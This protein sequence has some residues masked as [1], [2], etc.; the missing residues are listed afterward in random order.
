MQIF[1]TVKCEKEGSHC[2]CLSVVLIDSTF[3][4]TE[5]DN[6]Q[7]FLEKCKYIDKEKEVTKY[8][9]E[10]LE[11]SPDKYD[12]RYSNQELVKSLLS[13]LY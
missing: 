13:N 4:M 11:I 7:V 3:K 9:N 1:K 10:E 2:I 12:K 6:P 5:S 8:I